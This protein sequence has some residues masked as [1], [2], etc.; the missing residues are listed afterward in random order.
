MRYG[1]AKAYYEEHG[2]LNIPSKYRADGIWLAKWVNEQKQVYAG[3][4]KGKELSDEQVRRLEAI[5]IE[6]QRQKTDSR[7]SNNRNKETGDVR[8]VVKALGSFSEQKYQGLKDTLEREPKHQGL[9]DD[10]RR[11][12]EETMQNLKTASIVV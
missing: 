1:F 6:L 9:N 5:G 3:K 10:L 7:N 4:R 12:R 2:N 8:I 11:K